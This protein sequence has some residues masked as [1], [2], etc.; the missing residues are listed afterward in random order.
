M[1]TEE[2]RK[3]KRI[4]KETRQIYHGPA[5]TRW[6]DLKEVKECEAH[7]KMSVLLLLV[8]VLVLLFAGCQVS[9]VVDKVLVF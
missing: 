2:A 8:C 7:A 9:K 3:R 1:W 6:Q 4:K 5:F